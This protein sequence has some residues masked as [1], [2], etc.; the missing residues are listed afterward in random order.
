MNETN[1]TLTTNLNKNRS[2]AFRPIQIGCWQIGFWQIGCWQI[3]FCFLISLGCA[4]RP[5]HPQLQLVSNSDYLSLVG[6]NTKKEKVYEGFSNILDVR[7]TLLT[8]EIQM[9]QLDQKAR[10]FQWSPEQYTTEKQK[11]QE[12]LAK[13]TQIFISFFV[14]ERKHDDLHKKN[15]QWKIFLDMDGKR[16]E[17]LAKRMKSILA[18]TQSLYPHHTRWGTPYVLQFPVP[19]SAIS[20]GKEIKLTMTGPVAATVLV[21]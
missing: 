5:N 13:E 21:F 1:P 10:N 14:P 8:N 7:A 9:A 2:K 16:Y 11:L 6:A 12:I 15:S 18:E 3:G 17:G 20:A 4:H 19:T